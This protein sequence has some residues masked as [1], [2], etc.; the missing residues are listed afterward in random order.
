LLRSAAD[1]GAAVLL[2]T[3]DL[4]SIESTGAADSLAVMY[5]GRI[6]E[7]RPAPVVLNAPE[8]VYT[9]ALLDA[10]PSRG[11]HPIPGQPPEL[12]DLDPMHDF[13]DRLGP[14]SRKL[15]GTMRS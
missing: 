4:Q 3:H 1:R 14:A 12:T 10:L 11:L 9:R 8:H 15:K 7:H 2:I 5:A 6:V 13:T